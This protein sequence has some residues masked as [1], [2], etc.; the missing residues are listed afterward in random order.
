MTT[1]T[2]AQLLV[3]LNARLVALENGRRHREAIGVD[4]SA[5][6]LDQIQHASESDMAMG[7][8]ERESVRLGE[9][10]DALRRIQ[11]GTFGICLNCENAISMARLAALPWTATCL[12][13]QEATDG[14]WRHPRAVK[15]ESLL[16]AV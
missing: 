12:E 11:L 1:T 4:W 10:R 16:N 14:I 9:V 7:N 5:D 3:V 13:C 15:D 8:F 6:M 2:H